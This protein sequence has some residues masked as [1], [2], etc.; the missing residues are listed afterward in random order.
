MEVGDVNG[1]E[2]EV[3]D[4]TGPLPGAK[5][6]GDGFG[7]VVVELAPDGILVVDQGGTIVLA[8]RRVEDL[9]GYARDALVGHF[10][11][12]LEAIGAEHLLDLVHPAVASGLVELLEQGR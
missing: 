4:L 7:W 2:A 9:F 11:E 6:L 8:N 10:A 1:V 3:V 5:A 12:E